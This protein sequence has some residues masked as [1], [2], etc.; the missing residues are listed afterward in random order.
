VCFCVTD[1][2]T[3][4]TTLGAASI[5]AVGGWYGARKTA[6][7]S[8]K[9]VGAENE[10]LREQ[11]REDHLR[12]RQGTYH[13]FLA[14]D[15]ELAMMVMEEVPGLDVPEAMNLY[16]R[17]TRLAIGV[18]LFGTEEAR[19]K[20]TKLVEEYA[21]VGKEVD[22]SGTPDQEQLT[23]A[24]RGRQREINTA[25]DAVIEAMRNDVAPH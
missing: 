2:T 19:A 15:R 8:L 21:A 16:R 3:I 5:A 10:R 17:W 25:R 12:N 4:L 18:Q 13:D 11:H 1:W 14:A 22:L 6:E 24:F 23:A 20:V 7:V 9:Q